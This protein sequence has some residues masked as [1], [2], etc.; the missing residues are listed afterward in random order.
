MILFS[1]HKKLIDIGII[2]DVLKLI[3]LMRLRNGIRL[4]ELEQMSGYIYMIMITDM[5]KW[6]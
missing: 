3:V 1:V 2:N 5:N 4:Q 6:L